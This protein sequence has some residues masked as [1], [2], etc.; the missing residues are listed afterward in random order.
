M[1]L[2]FY[3]I[4]ISIAL[5]LNYWIFRLIF[6]PN[7]VNITK[8]DWDYIFFFGTISGI[9]GARAMACAEHTSK[10][11]NFH[12]IHQGGLT[13]YG[14]WHVGLLYFCMISYIYCEN[15]ILLFE[16]LILTVSF[17]SIFV[18]LGNYFNG[19]LIGT[20]SN[21]LNRRHPSQLYKMATEGFLMIFLVWWLYGTLGQGIIY[22]TFV[23]AYTIIRIINEFFKEEEEAMPNWFRSTLHPYLKFANFQAIL[24]CIV[25]LMVYWITK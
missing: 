13:S 17:E 12:L 25:Y 10:W 23:L 9:L 6:L 7:F 19:E 24:F 3:G 21:I 18:R 5:L 11:R 14:A 16:S 8:E 4:F 22:L 20:Y 1:K 2:N 15:P